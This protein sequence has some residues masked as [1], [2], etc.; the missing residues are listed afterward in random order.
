MTAARGWRKE[1]WGDGGQGVKVS[2]MKDE[3]VLEI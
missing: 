3:Y 2:V 1:K